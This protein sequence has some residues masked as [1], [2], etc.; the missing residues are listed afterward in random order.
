V[1]ATYRLFS[2]DSHLEIP[3]DWWTPR[4]PSKYRDRAP[5]RIKLP[6]GGDAVVGENAPICYGGTGHYS[7]KTPESFNPMVPIE[8]A[9]TVGS[10]PPQQ[11][12]EEQDADGVEGELLFPSNTAFKVARGITSNDAYQ[13][14]IAAYNEYL[15]EE[16]CAYAPDR[17]IGVGVLPHRG[18]DG[19]LREM[20]RCKKL[21]FKTVVLGR[22]PGGKG[23]PTPDDDR[24]WA[25]S[26]DLDMPLTIHTSL[27]GAGRG[28]V[29]LNYPRRPEG[30]LPPDDFLQRLY[31][32]GNHHCGALEATQMVI[33][34]V[35][36]RFPALKIYWAENNIG[37]LPF[38]F[39]QMDL[40]WE[41][42]H[43]WAEQLYGVQKLQRRPSEYLREHALWGFFDDPVGIKLR[44]EI[45]V[46]NI[47]WGSDFPHVVSTWPDSE[48]IL[49]RE[50]ASV[51]DEEQRKIVRDNCAT[52]LRLN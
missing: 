22:Y 14:V 35:F 20:E 44:H 38:Y 5:R 7:G 26:L 23:F 12:L 15:A 19:D 45:G 28:G 2:G 40:E 32:H 16:Y 3:P 1:A 34:G 27:G 24:F 30:D 46:D 29:L 17:L 25:A 11:R 36:D 41:R 31:R 8:Y 9:E 37:W 10:G 39:E 18:L 4:V 21:G 42:N 49:G 48:A 13:A 6:D 52:F 43:C 47:I 33:D 50:M 51:P